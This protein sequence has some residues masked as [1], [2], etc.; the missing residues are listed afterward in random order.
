M[1]ETIEY[2]L[3]WTIF[4]EAFATKLLAY[5]DKRKELVNKLQNVFNKINMPFPKL[6]EDGIVEEVDP[7]TVFGMFNKGITNNNRIK[8]LTGIAQEFDIP[9]DVPSSFDGIPVLLPMKSSFVHFKAHRGV[10][11]IDNLWIVFESALKYVENPSEENKSAFINSYDV[12]TTITGVNWN[13][14]MG[15]YWIRPY[16]FLNLDGKN[17]EYMLKEK[18]TD[19]IKVLPKGNEYLK[20]CEEVRTKIIDMYLY[21]SLPQLS[22]A[23]WI[24]AQGEY[25][26]SLKEYDPGITKEQWKSF[27]LEIELPDHPSPMQTLKAMLTLDGEASCKKLSELYGCKPEYY[28]ACVMNLGRRAVKYFK[29][30]PYKEGNTNKYFTLP[31][32]GKWTFENGTKYYVYR[33]RPEL[34]EALLE[35]DI[36][37]SSKIALYCEEEN[38]M[39]NISLNTILYGPPGTGKTFNTVNYAVAII[40]NKSIDSV[41]A[42]D[43]TTVLNRYNKYKENGLISFTT[44][45]Q[46]YGYEEFIEGIKPVMDEESQNISYEIKS[47]VF[48]EFCEDARIPENTEINHNTKLWKVILKSRELSNANTVKKECFRDG[49]IMFDWDAKESYPKDANA[50]HQII[51]FQ[52]KVNIGDIVVIYA[53]GSKNI[54]AVGIITSDA[55]FDENKQEYKWSRSVDWIEVDKI[56][57]IKALNGNTH[58]DNDKL[59]ELKR[60]NLVEFMKTI[61]PQNFTA[62]NKNYVFIIDEINRGNISKIFGELITL[63]EDSKRAGEKEA[64]SAILPYSG[65]SFSI[66]SNV[67]IVGT[68][69]T[70]DRSIALMDTALRRRFSFVEMMPDSNVLQ[71][72]KADK[73]GDID[74][75]EMLDTMNKRIE[76]L[77]DREHTIGHAFFT[78][79]QGENATID[80]LRMIFEKTIIPL[81]QEYFYEDYEKIRLVLGDNGKSD[82]NQFIKAIPTDTKELFKGSVDFDLPEYRYEINKDAFGKPESYI[83]IYK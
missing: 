32:Q 45:H 13:L 51:R 12:A 65:E 44:F 8:I 38:T 67:Y 66:P 5:I 7:F 24:D 25:L 19:K 6:E 40:E 63:I 42:E 29:I 35:L 83:G 50:Y 26:P 10:N 75:A 68:M 56:R 17:R 78:K 39:S 60:V 57:D 41:K 82:E 36:I 33:I 80:N 20:L 30:E 15:L 73:V 74:I 55:I 9:I 69:N 34:K 11:D 2:K 53:G 14:T 76:Y 70:A 49:K 48:K 1:D 4:F 47:G 43:Y 28:N 81:L 59:Q 54:D 79:L 52:E 22:H 61:L 77:Y 31:M 62:N 21:E 16:S 37:N 3:A 71:D 58:L 18:I 27:I 46:S 23:A 64:A 72:L